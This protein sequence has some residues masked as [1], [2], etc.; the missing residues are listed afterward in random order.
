MHDLAKHTNIILTIIGGLLT[1]VAVLI[2]IKLNT[3]KEKVE[4]NSSLYNKYREELQQECVNK[5]EYCDYHQN[6]KEWQRHQRSYKM[7]NNHS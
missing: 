3:I 5:S 4:K 2:L 1:I 7:L 6:L